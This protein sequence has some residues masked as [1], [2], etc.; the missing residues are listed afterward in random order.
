M[1]KSYVDNET[2]SDVQASVLQVLEKSRQSGGRIRKGINEATK[3]IERG[4]AKLVIVAGDVDPEE[5][6]MHLP[7]LCKEKGIAY[8]FVNT[9]DELGKAG[10]LGV[11]TSAIAIN[12]GGA[13]DEELKK[14][15]E[16]LGGKVT[17]SKTVEKKPAAKK[18]KE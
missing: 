14:V 2:P 3:A 5:I 9:K 7:V 4:E 18:K 16:K 17:E 1:A 11:G 10:G 15:I 8:C 12:S 6:V 13:A